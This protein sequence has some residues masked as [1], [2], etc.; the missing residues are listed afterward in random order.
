MRE[1]S[2]AVDSPQGVMVT[3]TTV[4]GGES[5]VVLTSNHSVRGML[6]GCTIRRLTRSSEATVSKRSV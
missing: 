5:V 4:N 3:G 1:S 2:K 6:L